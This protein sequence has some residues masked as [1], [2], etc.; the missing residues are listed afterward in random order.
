MLKGKNIVIIGGGAFTTLRS[1]IVS[2][3]DPANRSN[4]GDIHVVYGARTPGMLLYKE[5]LQGW[6]ARMTFT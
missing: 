3:L 6:A 5:E 2:I 1:S 4:F